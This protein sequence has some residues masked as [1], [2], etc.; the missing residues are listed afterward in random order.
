MAWKQITFVVDAHLVEE[1]SAVL[2]GLL[3]QAVT[4][5]NAGADEFYEVAF[6]GT[7]DWK[8]VAITGLFDAQVE[9]QQIIEFVH[10]RCADTHGEIPTQVALLEDQ[11]WERVWLSQFQPIEVGER[12]WVCP[13]WCS[14]ARPDH[15][16]I[17]LDPGLAFGTGTHATTH[18]CLQWLSKQN[19]VGETVLDYGAGSGILAIAALFSGADS[20]LAVDID[21]HAVT[22]ATE[23]A[24]RNNVA[25][26]MQSCLPSQVREQQYTLVIA[27]I[28]ADVILELKE[29]LLEHLAAQGTLLLTGILRDQADR[30]MDAFKPQLQFQIVVQDQWCLLI[31]QSDFTLHE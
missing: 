12:L 5:E 2:E 21:P 3:A 28:L 9:E 29:T 18:M 20:A 23:N 13:S 30:V 8:K 7:P 11:N 14:P 22:A 24:Q 10:R 1:L 25:D 26:R 16:N 27:N 31:G 19:L 15:R 4:T 6:P 17:I